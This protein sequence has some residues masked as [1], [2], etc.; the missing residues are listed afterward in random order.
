MK[1]SQQQQQSV[2]GNHR[3]GHKEP[4]PVSRLGQNKQIHRTD[5]DGKHEKISTTTIGL[6]SPGP[7]TSANGHPERFMA[8]TNP[9]LGFRRKR[10][11]GRK[12]R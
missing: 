3:D 6:F 4:V 1:N 11:D 8:R 9:A 7:N 12:P 2:Q 5:D 10:L